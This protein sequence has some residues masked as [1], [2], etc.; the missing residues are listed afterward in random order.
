MSLN[1][2]LVPLYKCNSHSICL[3]LGVMYMYV[4]CCL[5]WKQNASD[6]MMMIVT[7]QYTYTQ[8]KPF[9]N[10]IQFHYLFIIEMA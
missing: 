7:L 8:L 2:I 5:I 10:K 4:D 6:K 3:I 9:A 1:L